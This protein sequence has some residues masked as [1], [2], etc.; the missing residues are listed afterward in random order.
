MRYRWVILAVGVAGQ[1]AYSAVLFGV[2]VLAPKLQEHYGVSLG[3]IGVLLAASS[4]G[5]VATLLPWGLLTDSIGERAAI[6]SGLAGAG[7]GFLLTAWLPPFWVL[8]ALVVAAGGAGASVSAASGRAV[9]GWFAP[10][11]RGLALGLRQASVPLGGVIA[12]VGIPPL[13][14]G[15]GVRVALGSIGAL[16]LLGAAAALVW[17][18]EPPVV[19]EEIEDLARP[20]RNR[21]L[22][23]LSLSSAAYVCVQVGFTGF[24]VL[25]LHEERGLSLAAAGAWTATVHVLGG[26]GRIGFGALS[27]RMGTRLLLLRR[28]G[29]AMAVSTA[30]AAVFLS[31]PTRVV[32][33][34]LVVAGA[35]AMCWNGLAFTAVA[36]MAGRRKSGAALGLQQTALSVACVVTP[37][38]FAFVVDAASWRAAFAGL[39]LLPLVGWRLL[40]P[41]S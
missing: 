5:T 21:R 20:L 6:A 25:Y 24:L 22:W 8:V 37:I 33:P 19:E 12:S 4:V 14:E 13:L 17:L 38:A 27:D 29:I 16:S 3:E 32:V 23:R 35:L 10:S 9:M 39:A 30:A 34:L 36:E 2:P 40:A 41:L 1:A 11:E 15:W 7:V 26:A 18:R 28:L 31:A